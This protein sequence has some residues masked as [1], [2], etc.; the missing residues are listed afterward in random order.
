[1]FGW[2]HRYRDSYAGV[3]FP[4]LRHIAG[5]FYMAPIYDGKTLTLD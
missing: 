5:A 4:A 2:Q 3:T 1:M